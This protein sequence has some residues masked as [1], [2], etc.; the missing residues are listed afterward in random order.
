MQLRNS[1]EHELKIDT[2]K[3]LQCRRLK[4]RVLNETDVT[5]MGRRI[6]SQSFIQ[7]NFLLMVSLRKE[8]RGRVKGERYVAEL[9]A[10]H[11]NQSILH[12]TPN[13]FTVK[14]TD[15]HSPG[16]CREFTTK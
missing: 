3:L 8:S 9:A 4:L 13:N 2:E 14:I 15:R 7:C 11:G 6:L 16:L 12:R 1:D 10:V 5:S